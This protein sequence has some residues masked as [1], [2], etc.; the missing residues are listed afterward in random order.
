MSRASEG[1]SADRVR[2]LVAEDEF[3]LASLLEQDL[4]SAGHLVVGPFT[5]IGSAMQAANDEPLDLAILD[6]NLNGE[7]SYPVADKL[8][9]RGVPLILLTGY[10]ATD[11]PERFRAF[12]RIAKP[13]DPAR[14]IEEVERAVLRC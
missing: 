6:I 12:P 8:L 3:L 14:L 10:G 1:F 7:M 9:L 11:L 13:Y 2:V 5:H 4:I